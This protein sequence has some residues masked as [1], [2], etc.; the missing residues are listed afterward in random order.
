MSGALTMETIY[1]ITA[2][3]ALIGVW[4]NVQK[5]V[6]CFWIWTVTNAAWAWVD[7]QHGIHAQAALHVVYF[8]LAVYGIRKWSANDADA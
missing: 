4:L 5:H 2:L 8:C 1:W 3:A 6:A 7:Y